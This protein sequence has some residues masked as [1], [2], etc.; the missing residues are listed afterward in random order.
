MDTGL[1]PLGL[2]LAIPARPLCRT[3]EIP[4]LLSRNRHPSKPA[5]SGHSCWRN[6]GG[7]G[8]QL[9]YTVTHLAGTRSALHWIPRQL[10]IYQATLPLL[11]NFW[12]SDSHVNLQQVMWL[13]HDYPSTALKEFG[14]SEPG[15]PELRHVMGME[16]PLLPLL[17]V[18]DASNRATAQHWGNCVVREGEWQGR[19]WEATR[20]SFSYLWK[21]NS[22]KNVGVMGVCKVWDLIIGCHQL[23]E[24]LIPLSP[25]ANLPGPPWI[26]V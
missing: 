22:N 13:P 9:S 16:I 3:S 1:W 6:P 8:D 18:P 21:G 11:K 17:S 14:T 4:T 26:L 25:L 12:I 24:P 23:S 2:C 5:P 15:G 20:S 7:G 19:G 10:G